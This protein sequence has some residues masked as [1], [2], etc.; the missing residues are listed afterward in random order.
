MNDFLRPC[1]CVQPDEKDCE[2]CMEEA[3][4]VKAPAPCIC[5]QAGKPAAPARPASA[6]RPSHDGRPPKADGT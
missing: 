2:K 4:P 6:S 5:Q 1:N 3:V